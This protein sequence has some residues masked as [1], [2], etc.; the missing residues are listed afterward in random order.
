MRRSS[1]PGLFICTPL[2]LIVACRSSPALPERIESVGGSYPALKMTTPTS[3]PTIDPLPT[4]TPE[5]PTAFPTLILPTLTPYPDDVRFSIGQSWEGRDIWAWQFGEGPRSIVLV[6]GIHGGY[7][8]NTVVLVEQLVNHFRRNPDEVLSGIRLVLIPVANPDGLVRGSELEGRF[9]GRGV[10]LNR[11]WGCE[12][13]STA[14]LRDI[15]VDP[16]PRPFSEPE[17]MAL[18]AYFVAEPPDAAIFYHSA[19]GG[20]FVGACGDQPGALWLGDLL[21]E[22]TGYPHQTFTYYDVTGDATNWLAERGI[23]AVVIE[24]YTRDDP[25]FARN[26]AGVMALQRHFAPEGAGEGGASG[27]PAPAIRQPH[28]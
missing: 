5:S 23:P 4:G 9:N 18:R 16:G 17:T 10:D 28:P 26:L 1:L 25:E 24:L 27:Q 22:T 3:F 20:I 7:E 11:N 13:S 19:I 6:G 12:W 21:E 2:L 8:G 15:P 14:F